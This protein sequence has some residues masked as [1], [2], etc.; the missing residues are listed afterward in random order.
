[1][2]SSQQL[3]SL[4]QHA[5]R[6][7]LESGGETYRVED[8]ANRF[9]AAL[10]GAH[11]ECVVMPTG[12]FCTLNLPDQPPQTLI[13]RVKSRGINLE[14]IAEVN[15]VSRSF[16]KG[17]IT[18]CEA[19]CALEAIG[20]K[21]PMPLWASTLAVGLASACITPLIG[22]GA[23]DFILCLLIAFTMHLCM[24][25]I[26]TAIPLGFLHNMIGGAMAALMTLAGVHLL[27]M[28]SVMTIIVGAIMPLLPG[29]ASINALRDALRGDLVSGVARGLEVALIASCIATGVG[30]M[31]ALWRALGGG[32]SI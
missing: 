20:A 17:S 32:F 4:I 8:V 1:M 19:L 14:A 11:V 25:P 31:L 13:F 5:T 21:P 2:P 26:R 24:Q 29:L 9:S 6:I 23:A 27:H 12:V 3:L 10:P 22:G 30:S 16:V 15:Q 7:M 18:A 28:G